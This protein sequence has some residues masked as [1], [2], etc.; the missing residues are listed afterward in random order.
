MERNYVTVTLCITAV[1]VRCAEGT[2][3]LMTTASPET[4]TTAAGQNVFNTTDMPANT[5]ATAQPDNDYTVASKT[6]LTAG[7]K[8]VQGAR[9]PGGFPPT[10]D[11][12]PNRSYFISR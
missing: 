5:T 4:T 1:C 10:E 12:P 11:L 8:G 6:S 9:A 7:F 2:L 3:T